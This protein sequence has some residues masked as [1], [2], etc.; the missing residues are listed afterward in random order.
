MPAN[1]LT[2]HIAQ[3]KKSRLPFTKEQL[4]RIFGSQTFK[5]LR[6]ETENRFDSIS[7]ARFWIPLI[8]LYSGLRLEE[9]CQLLVEDIR[10]VGNL[11]VFDIRLTADS[12][13]KSLKTESSTRIVPIHPELVRLGFLKFVNKRASGQ[14]FSALPRTSN[15]TLGHTISKWFGRLLNKVT[16]SFFEENKLIELQ[17]RFTAT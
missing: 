14:L 11:T 16:L 2:T 15:G 13:F 1:S 7:C 10:K 3:V 5:D 17:P 6:K 9:I 4:E 12:G 8:S